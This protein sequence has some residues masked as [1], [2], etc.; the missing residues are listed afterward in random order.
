MNYR[1]FFLAVIAAA[2]L[3]AGL[4]AEP[5]EPRPNIVFFIA[6]DISQEDFGAYGHPSLKT[7]HID[8]LAAQGMRFD[9]AYL[10]ISSC[11]PSR[12]SIITGRYPHNT[13]A[14]EL[15]S[16]LP[17]DQL[18]FPELLREVGYHTALSGKNHMFRGNEDRAFDRV[19]DGGRP[20]G[21]K[22]WV[23]HVEKRPKDQPF[24]FWFASHDA[25]HSWAINDKAPVYDPA[26][27][28]VPPYMVDTQAVRENMARYYHEV[29]RFDH[30]IGQVTEALRKQGVL[31]NTLIVIAADNG[32]PFP[33]D[34]SRLYDSGIKTP[35]VVYYPPLIEKPAASN[36]LVSVIDLSATCLELAGV[37]IP[38][39]IQGQSFVPILKDPEA[40]VREIVFAEQNWHV[41]RNHSR[42]VRFGDYLYIKN[43]YLDQAN[44]S[45]ESDTHFASGRELW[46]AYVAGKTFPLQEQV[47]ANPLPEEELFQVSRDPHQMRSVADHPAYVEVR[48]QARRLLAEW[49]Q[50]TGDSI[51]ENPTP[52]RHAPPQVVDGEIQPAGKMTGRRNPHAEF[53]GA[54][55]NASE[56]NHPGPIRLSG[57]VVDR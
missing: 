48:D 43:N 29:S 44:L 25:H 35:W 9:N 55:E 28:I 50:Q 34:K 6:D 26:E 17:D 54:S 36:S 51:P 15:H 12:C 5:P 23:E 45:Y 13:G 7:P 16:R 18:R 31:E 1:H 22:D 33:R 42:M 56:I 37:D 46:Q 8:S 40:T 53:P 30:Y 14:P 57:D 32:R 49:T 4:I 41:Y 27:V 52:N 39:R 20:S 47:F 3:N 19:T 38:E 11:S 24:F 10:T 2:T 21:S